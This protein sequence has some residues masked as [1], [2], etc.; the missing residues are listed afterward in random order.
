[1]GRAPLKATGAS[2][3]LTLLF[4]TAGGTADA[5]ESVSEDFAV[6]ISTEL[7][8]DERAIA[9]SRRSSVGEEGRTS[10]PWICSFGFRSGRSAHHA[11]VNGHFKAMCARYSLY[12]YFAS[13]FARFSARFSFG[14][15]LGFF[16][17]SFFVSFAFPTSS[18]W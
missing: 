15:L 10:D 2:A 9:L 7:A 17:S 16:F 6:E 4:V 3:G 13:F 14:V 18:S 1:M 12:G 11:P 5:G 8:F